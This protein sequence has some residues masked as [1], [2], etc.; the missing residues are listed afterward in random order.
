M[1]VVLNVVFLFQVRGAQKNLTDQPVRAALISL[2]RGSASA[3]IEYVVLVSPIDVMLDELVE[4]YCI[5]AT[6]NT[7]V[8]EFHQL[9]QEQNECIREFAVRGSTFCLPD[10]QFT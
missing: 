10:L 4:R 8:C 2:L 7:L 9:S 1:N 3:F 5:T 6:H